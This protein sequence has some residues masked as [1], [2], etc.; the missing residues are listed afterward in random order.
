MFRSTLR[1]FAFLSLCI[2]AAAV[3]AA[4]AGA[5]GGRG[6]HKR[7]F[8]VPAPGKVTIDGKLDDWD[9]SA[10]IWVYV[11]PETAAQRSVRFAVMYDAEALYLSADVRDDTP[12]M[13][14]HD[15]WVNGEW[16]WDADACQF[17][18]VLDPAQG[19]PIN[20][21]SFNKDAKEDARGASYRR[22]WQARRRL[23]RI[24]GLQSLCVSRTPGSPYAR[25]A[26]RWSSPSRS[27]V[28]PSRSLGLA[29][30]R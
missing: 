22:R 4:P 28:L 9:L 21:S 23:L 6:R 18:M 20:Q 12:I 14:R 27:M 15:P 10:R 2:A 11:E 17:R 13:N 30:A 26:V 19:Y 7:M 16:A 25:P 8:A 3:L 24:P 1:R 5:G 29:W